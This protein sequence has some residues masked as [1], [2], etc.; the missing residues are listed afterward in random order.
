MCL[1]KTSRLR[2]GAGEGA[3]VPSND[4][5]TIETISTAFLID[6]RMRRETSMIAGIDR[7]MHSYSF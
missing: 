6:G 1:E 7:A 3:R 4:K 5:R 2:R